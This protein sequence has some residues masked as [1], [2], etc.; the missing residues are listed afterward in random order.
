MLI[1]LRDFY[2]NFSVL[3]CSTYVLYMSKWS[4]F[5]N[6]TYRTCLYSVSEKCTQKL[7]VEVM[8]SY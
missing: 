6:T 1:L 7:Y 4:T 3:Y 2:V 8:L 5:Q